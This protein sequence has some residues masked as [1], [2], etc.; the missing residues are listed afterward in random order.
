MQK[1]M[2][3]K[4]GFPPMGSQK[5]QTLAQAGISTSTANRYF[6]ASRTPKKPSPTFS[7]PVARKVPPPKVDTLDR[8]V[9]CRRSIRQVASTG[10]LRRPFGQLGSNNRESGC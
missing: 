2:A 4:F 10:E 3:V 6:G 8:V 9:R 7:F 5:E 1:L